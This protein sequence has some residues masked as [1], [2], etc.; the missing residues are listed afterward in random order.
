[1]IAMT[2]IAPS[3]KGNALMVS[4]RVIVEMDVNFLQGM[5]VVSFMYYV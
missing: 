5:R 1:M 2:H 4:A 3:K